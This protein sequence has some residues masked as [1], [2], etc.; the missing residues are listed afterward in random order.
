MLADPAAEPQHQ[1]TGQPCGRDPACGGGA[2]LTLGT[3]LSIVVIGL[4]GLVVLRPQGGGPR[5]WPVAARPY[6]APLPSGL[7]H[8]PRLTG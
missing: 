7:D 6:Q 1:P 5:L 4:A 3:F 8:P 2:A